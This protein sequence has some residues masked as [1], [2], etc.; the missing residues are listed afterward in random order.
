[1]EVNAI[2]V[3]AGF[4]TGVVFSEGLFVRFFTVGVFSKSGK[5][6]KMFATPPTFAETTSMFDLDQE[7]PPL[8]CAPSNSVPA[9]LRFTKGTL[10][11]SESPIGVPSALM[12]VTKYMLLV[13]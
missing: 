12:M 2:K 6:V 4:Q 5:N 1:M 8:N 9:K 10:R 11:P 3:P 13:L 7:R